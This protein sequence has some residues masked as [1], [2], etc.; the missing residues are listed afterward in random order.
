MSQQNPSAWRDFF[1]TSQGAPSTGSQR[2]SFDRPFGSE[3]L[4]YGSE[5]APAP[6]PRDS[7]LTKAEHQVKEM[8][9]S[10][11]STLQHKRVFNTSLYTILAI[12]LGILVLVILAGVLA[13]AKKN[14]TLTPVKKPLVY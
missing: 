4:S 5:K 10:V 2:T 7:V 13:R 1:S 14:G 9:H 12:L 6:L 3:R 8:A 11:E